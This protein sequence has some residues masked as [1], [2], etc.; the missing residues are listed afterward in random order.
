MAFLGQMFAITGR[1]GKVGGVQEK[2]AVLFREIA[3]IRRQSAGFAYGVFIELI[4]KDRSLIVFTDGGRRY[5]ND[6]R[7][8]SLRRAN[9]LLGGERAFVNAWSE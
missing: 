2:A 7:D 8:F 9:V 1:S 4:S 6:F 3:V 5:E